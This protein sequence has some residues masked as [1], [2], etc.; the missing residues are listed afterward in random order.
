MLPF[1][2]KEIENEGFGIQDANPER[3]LHFFRSFVIL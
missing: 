2:G 3:I 1:L